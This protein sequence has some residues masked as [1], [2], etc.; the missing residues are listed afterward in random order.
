MECMNFTKSKYSILKYMF[1]YTIGVLIVLGCYGQAVSSSS[2]L[3]QPVLQ[4]L[5][6]RH[7]QGNGEDV[8]RCLQRV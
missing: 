4:R 2:V 7:H 6:T 1:S 8:T 5:G 3:I